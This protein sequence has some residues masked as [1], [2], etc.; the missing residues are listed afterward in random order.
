[1]KYTLMLALLAA[2]SACV[3]VETPHVPRDKDTVAPLPPFPPKVPTEIRVTDD[4]GMR[5]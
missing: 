3:H 2:L 5:R 1:M 4:S